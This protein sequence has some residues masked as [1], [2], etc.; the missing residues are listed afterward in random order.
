MISAIPAPEAGD[1]TAAQLVTVGE[2]EAGRRLDNFLMSLLRGVPRTHVYRMIR[3][4]QVRVNSGRAGADRRLLA[5]DRV[6][7]PPLRLAVDAQV[8][9]LRPGAAAWI[10][11][12]VLYEDKNLLVLD[13][14]AGLASHGGSGVS[15][16]AIE[17]LR[18]AR[19][20]EQSLGLVHRLDRDTSGCLLLARRSSALRHLQAQFRA[21]TVEK[22]YLALLTG[23]LRAAERLVDAP[24]YTAERRG[25]ERHVRVDP[26]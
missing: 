17:L 10:E 22:T 2:E 5:G 21:G 16:G 11:A 26:A 20:A 19:P 15:L 24:L 14:P 7:I 9:S 18:L 6:R 12:R 4:G 25:G 13:K 23:T 8:T 1:K 3:S